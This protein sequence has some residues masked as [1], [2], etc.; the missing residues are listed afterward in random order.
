MQ[1]GRQGNRRLESRTVGPHLHSVV[2]GAALSDGSGVEVRSSLGGL[3]ERCSGHSAPV[4]GGGRHLQVQSD[5]MFPIQGGKLALD[6]PGNPSRAALAPLGP[7]PVSSSTFCCLHPLKL[8]CP[9]PVTWPSLTCLQIHPGYAA[10][11]PFL[12][13]L[14][15]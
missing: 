14:H 5:T 2:E 6:A 15:V 13:P 10:E 7:L 3:G 4:L 1:T 9:L 11:F 12:G 8:H